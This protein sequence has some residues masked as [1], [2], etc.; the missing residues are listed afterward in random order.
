ML[1]CSNNNLFFSYFTV[2]QHLSSQSVS[3][4]RFSSI[5]VISPS[6]QKAQCALIGRLGQCAG[7]GYSLQACFR[8]IT[9]FTITVLDRLVLEKKQHLLGKVTTHY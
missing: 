2:V 7:I 6:F 9:S 4:F 8:N 3:N 5:L 1:E